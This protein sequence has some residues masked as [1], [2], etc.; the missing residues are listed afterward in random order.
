MKKP[1]ELQRG[2]TFGYNPAIKEAG[3]GRGG[4][5]VNIIRKMNN[6]Q[7]RRN[8]FKRQKVSNS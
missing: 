2:D 3:A 7:Y 1:W 4:G 8:N 6:V 5:G